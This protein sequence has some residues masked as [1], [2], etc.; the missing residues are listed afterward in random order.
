MNFFSDFLTRFMNKAG[1]M[2]NKLAEKDQVRMIVR[3]VSSNLVK[4]LQMMNPKTFVDLYDDG[5]Q[6]EE[7]EN[8]K[9]NNIRSEGGKN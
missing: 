9:K 2:K 5:L 1:M 4:R 6:A 3:N 7:I 8:E